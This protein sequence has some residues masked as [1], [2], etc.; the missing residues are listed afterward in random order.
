MPLQTPKR[1][2][3]FV[4]AYDIISFSK[5]SRFWERIL[6]ED[7]LNDVR[8]FPPVRIIPSI[9][10]SEKIFLNDHPAVG[11]CAVLFSRGK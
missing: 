9:E 2:I 6:F 8:S 1:G 11:S 7:E 3:L 4:I 10:S 5:A